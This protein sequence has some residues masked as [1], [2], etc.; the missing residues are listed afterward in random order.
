MSDLGKIFKIRDVKMAV[1]DKAF[2]FFSSLIGII[3]IGGLLLFIALFISKMI[4]GRKTPKVKSMIS[5]TKI[6]MYID[7][8][9]PKLKG[10]KKTITL[11]ANTFLLISEYGIY[12]FYYTKE[13]GLLEGSYQSEWLSKKG[14][15]AP[16]YNPF[17]AMEK[18]YNKYSLEK[19][20]GKI[21]LTSNICYLNVFDYV[22][23]KVIK[24]KN[25]LS[26]MDKIVGSEKRYSPEEVDHIY[27][28]YQNLEKMNI[29]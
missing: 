21:L 26:E 8:Y 16:V 28:Q 6:K 11:S 22:D 14:E 2:Y 27:S 18:E 9:I 19:C 12:F 13:E 1:G 25:F 29:P 20:N 5:V 7:L 23:E 10:Y 3:I 17:L 4:K 15:Q 24:E